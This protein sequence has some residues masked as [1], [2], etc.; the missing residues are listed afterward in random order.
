VNTAHAP[1]ST[2]SGVQLGHLLFV[3]LAMSGSVI[4]ASVAEAS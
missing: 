3:V 2:A 1:S 4:V